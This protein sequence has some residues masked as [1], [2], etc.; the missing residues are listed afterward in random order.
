MTDSDLSPWL[1]EKIQ[2]GETILFLGAGASIGA[3][4]TNGKSAL[5]AN[6]LRDKIADKFLGGEEKD[7]PLVRVADY[8]KNEAG[9][10]NVQSFIRSLFQPLNPAE[11][12][13]LIPSFRWHALVT[14]NYD[15]VIERAYDR[16][17][18]KLQIVSPIL[19]DGDNF[20]DKI[21]DPK[22]VPYLKLHG[23]INVIDD[24]RLPLILGSEE[25]AKYR[26]NRQRLFDHFND[27]GRD[28]PIIFCGTE[29]ADPNI[30]QILFDLAD[31]EINR[32]QYAVI[33]P[34]LNEYDLRMWQARRFIP[35]K[36]SFEE[37][38]R[39]L[40]SRIPKHKRVLSSLRTPQEMS[41]GDLIT[42]EIQPTEQLKRYLNTELEH[43]FKGMPI[44]G[45]IPKDFYRGA[46]NSWGAIDQNLDIKRRVSDDIILDAV[47]DDSSDKFVRTFLLQGH[48][49]SGKS[50]VLRRVAWDAVNDHDGLVFW[51]REGGIIR[52]N[53]FA[54]LYN[55]INQRLTFLIEDAIPEVDD[56]DKLLEFCEKNAVKI[57]VIMGARTNE[58]NVLGTDIE[59]KIDNEYELR[60][61]SENESKA[62]IKKLSK[63]DCLGALKNKTEAERLEYFKLTAERQILVALHEATSGKPF[64][65]IVCDEY[66]KITPLEAQI[67]YL[68]I[69]TLNRFGI[70][71][72][73]GLIS[74]VSG[75]NFE[76]FTER[77]FRPLEHVIRTIYDWK[78][79][80]MLYKSRHPIIADIVFNRVL[81]GQKERADQIIRM[82][83]YMNIDYEADDQA[84]KQLIKGRVIANLFSNR[85]FADQIFDASLESSASKPYIEHQRAIFELHHHNGSIQ[86]ASTH[87]KN[88]ELHLEERKDRSVDH[89]KAL[90]LKRKALDSDIQVEKERLRQEAKTILSRQITNA[91]ESYPIHTLAEIYIDELNERLETMGNTDI[92]NIEQ[93]VIVELV[94]RS[95]ETIQKGLQRFPDDQ[96]LLTAEARLA[97]VLEDESRANTILQKA[98]ET[99]PRSSY[100]AVRLSRYFKSIGKSDLVIPTL[101]KCLNE[102][103]SSKEIHLEIARNLIDTDEESMTEDIKRHLRSSFTDGDTNFEAQFWFARH[104]F[105][106]GDRSIA[107]LLFDTLRKTRIPPYIRNKTRGEIVD[108]DKNPRTFHGIIKH[109]AES[110]CFVAC[111]EL[112]TDIFIHCS[113]FKDDNWE[114]VM[115]YLSLTFEVVFSLRGPNGI[116]ARI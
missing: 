15:L 90:I 50:V 21:R 54:E 23:C 39:H 108:S 85:A 106:Y 53:L 55:L 87:V 63:F 94:R 115:P 17:D 34:S 25:Y 24:E 74:R 3:V 22:T 71:V 44:P 9:L 73:A 31:M 62:L 35:L 61:L 114:K 47:L 77:L 14:T 19:R 99:N 37:F 11:F 33:S 107:K 100:L 4:G 69:C 66:D 45:T 42:S 72:R 2:N 88:A 40:E 116:N 70:G 38:M 7:K 105:I 46:S 10:K 64:E 65:D 68:D 82:I 81:Q 60:D 12:H 84:F 113:D 49:G 41:I 92:E 95:E 103:P 79:R 93:R 110:Y 86:R 59:H 8:A 28:H 20:S 32:P 29:I 109:I 56:I 1:V 98:F 102:D 36:V 80:D 5:S 97:R 18:Q 58:W 101:Q 43:V 76:Y 89:T 112:N 6:E 111:A 26:N 67:L 27:W 57:N 96:F 13:N 52:P 83:R 104:H 75:I 30:Q 78:S 91:Y 48:A 51:L 16:N